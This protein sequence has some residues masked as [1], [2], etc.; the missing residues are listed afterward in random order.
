MSSSVIGLASPSEDEE[1]S[2][3]QR[4]VPYRPSE[5]K[6]EK[7]GGKQTA[8]ALFC[9][10]RKTSS[11]SSS[12][13]RRNSRSNESIQGGS[14]TAA[15]AASDCA[16][17]SAFSSAVAADSDFSDAH[18]VVSDISDISVMSLQHEQQ[19]RVAA[20][21]IPEVHG[22][23]GTSQRL[24]S[25]REK[26][27]SQLGEDFLVKKTVAS[28]SSRHRFQVAK[29]QEANFSLQRENVNLKS[30]VEMLL[31]HKK[32]DKLDTSDLEE[33]KHAKDALQRVARSDFCSEH[34]A[35]LRTAQDE[36]LK[37]QNEVAKTEM[38]SS[39]KQ[40]E[41][42]E[43]RERLK[44][45]QEEHAAARKRLM[46]MKD[47]SASV[48][49]HASSVQSRVD[50]LEEEL[51][52]MAR[53]KEWYVEQ[54][55][56]A[57]ESRSKIQDELLEAKKQAT[58]R[59]STIAKLE[60]E[61]EAAKDNVGKVGEEFAQKLLRIEQEMAEQ[62]SQMDQI[63][64]EKDAVI[65]QLGDRVA[66]AEGDAKSVDGISRNISAMEGSLSELREALG[67]KDRAIKEAM[68]RNAE[69]EQHKN[70][71]QKEL[72]EII[73]RIAIS[74]ESL[75]K[76]KAEC[77]DLQESKEDLSKLLAKVEQERDALAVENEEQKL[78]MAESRN[79]SDRL[80]EK[81]KLL[82][83]KDKE[84]ELQRDLCLCLESKNEEQCQS[85]NQLR[86]DKDEM[87]R[88]FVDVQ[89][90][91][92][93]I[94]EELE[95]IIQKRESLSR[96]LLDANSKLSEE[97]ASRRDAEDRIR[98]LSE[99]WES[100][101]C[102]PPPDL[103]TELVA[104][105][106]DVVK[107]EQLEIEAGE[108]RQEKEE[109]LMSRNILSGKLIEAE[110]V[111][112]AEVD[113]LKAETVQKDEII[114]TMRRDIE[115]V[116]MDLGETKRMLDMG[117]AERDRADSEQRRRAEDLEEALHEMEC[118]KRELTDK[119]VLAAELEEEARSLK[120]E[121]EV[122][123]GQMDKLLQRTEQHERENQR[124]R[125]NL[126]EEV[127]SNEESRA[128][129][130]H[131]LAR[132]ESFAAEYEREVEDLTTAKAKL[133]EQI[134]ALE[135]ANGRLQGESVL[136]DSL[137]EQVRRLQEDLRGDTALRQ[138]LVKSI[139]RARDD[140]GGE[141]ASLE[142]S[143][144]EEK[145]R[146]GRAEVK[147]EQLERESKELRDK[148]EDMNKRILEGKTLA[149]E[150]KTSEKSS[151]EDTRR[152]LREVECLLEEK[153]RS[154][155]RLDDHLATLK[156]N[157]QQ[158]E[159]ELEEARALLKLTSERQEAA[160]ERAREAQDGLRLELAEQRKVCAGLAEER[161]NYRAQV[162]QMNLALR[163]GLEHIR[164]L[165]SRASNPGSPMLSMSSS[166]VFSEFDDPLGL[167][168]DLTTPSS[169][170]PPNP[171]AAR[172]LSNLQACLASLKAEMAMLQT[173]LAPPPPASHGDLDA[174][175]PNSRRSTSCD[176]P[177]EDT[178]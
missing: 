113:K 160:V 54:L 126:D 141:I 66:A 14:S 145:A 148:C 3:K 15:V 84:I 171:P 34:R 118:V 48:W 76:F 55:E 104:L 176:S 101:E 78:Q 67:K 90:E 29:L 178:D 82:A 77:S 116:E 37:M 44:Q 31:Q 136:N 58:A 17:S 45:T 61:L 69:L 42:E 39:R 99:R 172:N 19:F 111:Y 131:K 8:S 122:L 164:Q 52:S 65:A 79:L 154:V 93:R 30:Q 85:L 43:V 27:I 110:K 1:A 28:A 71:A 59:A 83:E 132:L 123:A 26:L 155:C 21:A 87:C 50:S 7:R 144:A 57:K 138:D 73:E 25:R 157:L 10:T 16:S 121:N 152:R 13:A 163:N 129:Q 4:A 75:D 159:A 175:V 150:A 147:A 68:E 119:S 51:K 117:T 22:D 100:H 9:Q 40:K 124:L 108:L 33:A 130:G 156:F 158:R 133:Q 162:R 11:S 102:S 153:A 32:T 165:R 89:A 109:L 80:E 24:R 97:Q 143:L 106:R 161:S 151:D 168:T 135:D 88:R 62:E 35:Q 139:E 103:N 47:G 128:M 64:A 81:S 120:E 96:E 149:E 98:D 146:R 36:I 170:T 177:R 174:S 74:E 107:L 137:R 38:E 20:A 105:R 53:S 91:D 115:V 23:A 127:A 112:E 169:P 72:S 142:T 18:S 140:L 86:E 6:I 92:Q 49:S 56:A 95:S 41:L 167:M 60:G 114:N 173:K 125:A 5:I 70:S 12:K 46:E 166:R 2:I 63:Q 134:I 94:R